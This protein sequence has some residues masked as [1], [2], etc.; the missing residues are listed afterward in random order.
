MVVRS[1]YL[2]SKSNH[3]DFPS[4]N[5]P[6]ES[7]LTMATGRQIKSI[8]KGSGISWNDWLKFL[9]PHK[10]LDHTNMAAKALEHIREAGNSTSPE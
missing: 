2:P 5:N 6:S 7:I 1:P 4:T 9:A 10:D 3:R 8:E